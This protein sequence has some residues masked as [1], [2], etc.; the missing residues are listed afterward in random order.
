MSRKLKSKSI[1]VIICYVWYLYN[2][3]SEFLG[4]IV[5][6]SYGSKLVVGFTT[7]YAISVYHH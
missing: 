4:A 5:A 2:D 3:K 1:F 7:I 6:G